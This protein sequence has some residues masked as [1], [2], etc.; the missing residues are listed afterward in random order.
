[1]KNVFLFSLLF[2]VLNCK[3]SFAQ[4]TPEGIVTEFFDLYKNKGGDKAIEYI[5]STNPYAASSK[6][7]IMQ[8]EQNLKTAMENNGKFWGYDL[9]TT[10]KAG[11]NLVMLTYLVKHDRDPITFRILFYKPNDKWQLQKFKFDDKMD[12]ELEE[13]SKAYRLK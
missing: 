7:A 2:S 13:A 9:L 6:E 8:L 12:D 4:N 3:I 1:M 10:R 11:E 5:F